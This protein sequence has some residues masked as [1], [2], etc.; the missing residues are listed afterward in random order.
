MATEDI[1]LA[2]PNALP[3]TIAAQQAIH[4]IGMP[5]GALALAEAVAF[6]ASSPK[7]NAIYAA[8]GEIQ[9]DIQQ[10]RN[11]P[12]PIHLRNAPTKLMKDLG[13]GKGYLYAHD[14]EGANVDQEH[15]P[16][17]LR[18]KRYYH[19]TDRGYESKLRVNKKP[20]ET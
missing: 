10:T 8:W 7:S 9:A 17:R 14:F 16:E 6:L 18:G 11:D 3:I 15:L 5:E 1:G 13:Y 20:E 2:N 4:F 12:V 19:P